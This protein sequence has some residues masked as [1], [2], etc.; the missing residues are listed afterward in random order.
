MLLADVYY[1]SIH[2]IHAYGVGNSVACNLTYV[3]FVFYHYFFFLTF[4][5]DVKIG[6]KR[7]KVSGLTVENQANGWLVGSNRIKFLENRRR[8]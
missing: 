8:A 7:R 5:T 3:P 6:I 4:R 1:S 2:V